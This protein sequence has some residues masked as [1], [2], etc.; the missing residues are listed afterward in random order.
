MGK[1]KIT[2]FVEEVL[3]DFLK[4]NQ[5]EL[6]NSEFKKEG[7]D[8]FLRIYIDKIQDVSLIGTENELFVSTDDCEKVSRYLSEILDKDDPIEQNYYLEVSSPGMDRELIKDSDFDKYK[9]KIVEI[10]FYKAFNGLKFLEGELLGLQ[11]GNILIKNE[12]EIS[13]P[14]DLVSK[15][16]LAV[17]F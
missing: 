8:W 3:K 1:Q 7:K 12:E 10:K 17:I 2:D 4:E 5:M 9:G 15:V 6:Y 16:N 11:D 14:R 13:I